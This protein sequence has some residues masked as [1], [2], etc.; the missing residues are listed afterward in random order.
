VDLPEPSTPSKV[1]SLFIGRPPA[2]MGVVW[3]DE[4]SVCFA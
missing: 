1:M 3:V 4:T 2:I